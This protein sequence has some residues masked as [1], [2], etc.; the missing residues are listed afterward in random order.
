MNMSID[1]CLK[2]QAQWLRD[3]GQTPLR[4]DHLNSHPN[5]K[6][7]SKQRKVGTWKERVIFAF[8]RSCTG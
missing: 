7:R 1:R 3:Q 4:E 8:N 2:H 5:D 6:S